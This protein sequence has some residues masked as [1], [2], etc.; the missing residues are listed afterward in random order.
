VKDPNC[1]LPLHGYQDFINNFGG[2]GEDIYK[3][4]KSSGAVAGHQHSQ[5]HQPQLNSR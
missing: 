2:F 1:D 4:Y 5:Q 3:A